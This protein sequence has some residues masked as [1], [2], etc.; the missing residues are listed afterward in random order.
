MFWLVPTG[1][2]D[3]MY[4]PKPFELGIVFSSI[5]ERFLDWV[6]QTQVRGDAFPAES[7]WASATELGSSL[8]ESELPLT[9]AFKPIYEQTRNFDAFRNRPIVTGEAYASAKTVPSEQFDASTSEVSKRIGEALN[10]SPQRL[11]HL[12][13]AYGGS[14]GR[15]GLELGDRLLG[16]PSDRVSAG[17]NVPLVGSLVAGFTDRNRGLTDDEQAVRRRVDQ[18]RRVE[19]AARPLL[20]V[21]ESPESPPQAVVMAERKLA[22]LGERYGDLLGPDDVHLRGLTAVSDALSD[23][24]AGER[25]VREARRAPAAERATR[26]AAL[27]TARARIAAAARAGRYA[28]AMA[29]YDEFVQ[30]YQPLGTP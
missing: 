6:Y 11:D 5:P 22:M 13:A 15:L 21:L 28:D 18:V 16:R 29:L 12:V 20:R 27:R 26:L 7:A 3:F 8:I 30:S 9:D 23:L 17:A 4:L 10:V 2:G 19:N 14:A 1:G 24:A 25:D